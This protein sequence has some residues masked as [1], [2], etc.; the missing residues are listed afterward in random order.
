MNLEKKQSPRKYHIVDK[1]GWLV[2][3]HDSPLPKNVILKAMQR[4]RDDRIKV[5]LGPFFKQRPKKTA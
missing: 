1:D 2:V 5:T 4:S 3:V